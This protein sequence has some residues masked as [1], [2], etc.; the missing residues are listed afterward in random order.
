VNKIEN[1]NPTELQSIDE[2]IDFYN[3]TFDTKEIIKNIPN[4]IK[5]SLDFKKNNHENMI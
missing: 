2:F 5:Y 1:Y 3:R 4:I